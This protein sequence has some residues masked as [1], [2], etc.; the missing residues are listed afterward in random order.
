MIINQILYNYVLQLLCLDGGAV[1]PFL[2]CADILLWA[3]HA[4]SNYKGS[5]I[6]GGEL[7]TQ[8][9]KYLS[10]AI[11]DLLVILEK[12]FIFY[13]FKEKTFCVS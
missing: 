3:R 11:S 12:V 13:E 2:S 1:P 8:R 9:R 4:T 6:T 10:D 5:A 7:I